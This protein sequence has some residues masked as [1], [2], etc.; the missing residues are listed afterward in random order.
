[1]KKQLQSK[2]I[3]IAIITMILS[4]AV[5][6]FDR[7]QASNIQL[8]IWI[9]CIGLICK[10]I[11]DYFLRLKT[12]KPIE[13]IFKKNIIAMPEEKKEDASMVSKTT[14]S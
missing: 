12:N 14:S 4:I 1:M 3:V 13:K 2:T 10:A 11:L 7:F 5:L 9:V 6:V 8:P